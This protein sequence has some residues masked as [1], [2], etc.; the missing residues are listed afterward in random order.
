MFYLLVYFLSAH[1]QTITTLPALCTSLTKVHIFNAT[2]L[3]DWGVIDLVTS[4][5]NLKV[6]SFTGATRLTNASFAKTVKSLQGLE[7]LSITGRTSIIFP[8]VICGPGNL[9]TKGSLSLLRI[10]K[11][12]PQHSPIAPKLRSL[13]LTGHD[14]LSFAFS[15]K[16]TSQRAGLEIVLGSEGP[17]YCTFWKGVLVS[18]KENPSFSYIDDG[19]EYQSDR[20][21]EEEEEEEEEEDSDG[22]ELTNNDYSY[23][24][25]LSDSVVSG[26][27]LSPT[28][29]ELT[30][31]NGLYWE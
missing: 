16:L 30:P 27:Y 15:K 1:L 22:G 20:M 3:T 7:M 29:G 28:T 8:R 2:L 10:P 11:S 14:G 5:P 4:C 18:V 13:V 9:K 31:E 24:C 17:L 23:D 21:S 25:F 12:R 26:A 6:L 19:H